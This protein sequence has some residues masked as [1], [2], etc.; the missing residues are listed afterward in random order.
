MTVSLRRM[1]RAVE[2]QV[3]RRA[4]GEPFQIPRRQYAA[5]GRCGGWVREGATLRRARA[6]GASP[7]R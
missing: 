7:G 6:G 4:A 3:P 5:A 2:D 1:R